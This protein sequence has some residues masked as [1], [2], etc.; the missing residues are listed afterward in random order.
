MEFVTLSKNSTFDR[1]YLVSGLRRSGNHLLLQLLTCSFKDNSVLFINDMP[2]LYY[3]GSDNIDEQYSDFIN[4][5]KI[6][7]ELI[8]ISYSASA[9][10][11]GEYDVKD[12]LLK[13]SDINN[14][15]TV[16]RTWTDKKKILIIS[17][18]DQ[19]I[20]RLEQ[21]A[22]AFE[23]RCTTMYKII[24]L[25]DILNCVSS[26]FQFLCKEKTMYK[27][28]APTE[29]YEKLVASGGFFKTDMDTISM[30]KHHASY[31][32]NPEYIIFNYNKFICNEEYKFRLYVS[33]D[34]PF[35]IS[36]CEGISTYGHGSSY[37]SKTVDV[38]SLLT[39]F[40]DT[41]C[42]VSKKNS[43]VKTVDPD[44]IRILVGI[45]EDESIMEL[46]RL[47]FLMDI[48]PSSGTANNTKFIM[49]LCNPD[50]H[51]VDIPDLK[52]LVGGNRKSKKEKVNHINKRTIRNK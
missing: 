27:G 15:E 13:Q 25:R 40:V 10:N 5:G 3:N 12:C 18:E 8:S 23:L 45:L 46:L 31:L 4:N 17:F 2:D 33:L 32:D 19:H 11:C 24:I 52:I 41:T 38:Y 51:N 42:V 1:I 35:N 44:L 30:W 39:R 28:V 49:R 43:R 50:I 9:L 20:D 7:K 48:Q 47:Q 21:I 34:L 37:N 14:L 26:R 16:T 29:K 36:L 22:K 6:S